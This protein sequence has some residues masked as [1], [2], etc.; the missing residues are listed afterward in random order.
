MTFTGRRGF[1]ACWL[2]LC[3]FF[4]ACSSATTTVKQGEQF[5]HIV[6]IIQENRSFDNMFK[7]FPG[8]DSASYGQTSKQKRVPLAPVS[9]AVNYDIRHSYEDYLAAYDSGRM[10][11]FEKA[12]INRRVVSNHSTALPAYPQFGYVPPDEVAPYWRLANRFGIADK[13]FQSNYDQSFGAHLFLIGAQAKGVINVPNGHPWG[14]D[15]PPGSVIRRLPLDGHYRSPIFPCLNMPTLGEEFNKRA[16]SWAYYAPAINN[17]TDWISRRRRIGT[18]R[19]QVRFRNGKHI[20]VG[21]L[22]SAYDAIPA[23]RYGPSWQD[24]VVSPETTIL[25]DIKQ[26]RLP[27]VSWVVPDFANSDH[28]G[29]HSKT[30]PAWVSSIC[31]AIGEGPYWK[32]TAIIV[33]WDDSGGWFDH[34]KPPRF[35]YEGAGFRV[36]MIVASARSKQHYVSHKV[37]EFGSI[38]KFVEDN[39]LLAPIAARDAGADD[40]ADFF[41]DH[42]TRLRYER[43][44]PGT[45]EKRILRS[46]PSY[47]PPD[48]D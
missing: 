16:I 47:I 42:G 32:D 25:S 37:R 24:N 5:R 19:H 41:S 46:K 7:D 30:G 14:C 23:I 39:F 6:I 13:L 2:T 12:K 11:G 33:V 22:W 15:S 4:S 3:W 31:D 43:L 45:A 21:Q 48:D 10:D 44:L 17:W 35:D 20:E 1:S 38:L 8:A 28:S 26:R 34:V 29:S 36:P 27:Q 9:L 18:G 40:L